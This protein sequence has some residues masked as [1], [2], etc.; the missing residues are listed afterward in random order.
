MTIS[1]DQLFKSFNLKYRGPI[2][3]GNKLD[4]NFNGVYVISLAK[5]GKTKTPHKSPLKIC[6][7]TYANWISEAKNL[8]IQNVPVTDIKQVE[9][10]LEKFWK[11]DQN[12]LY[13][14]ES[15]SKT[16]PIQKRV[17]Q[18]YIHKVGQKGP[19]S[20]GYWLKLISQL[21][22]VNIYYAEC[23]NP[24]EVE[25]KLLMK[26]VELQTGKSFYDLTNF[27]N[28]FPFANLKVDVLKSHEIKAT[29][30]DNKRSKQAN[31]N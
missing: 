31:D 12:I 25:F 19:H 4:A 13:I 15:T 17:N 3:W 22:N 9:S 29:T 8:N 11:T 26:F 28:C 18:F 27:S 14:G 20:G 24:R 2:K 10:Y 16:N 7:T 6:E 5:S 1:V 21:E 23:S 30:N